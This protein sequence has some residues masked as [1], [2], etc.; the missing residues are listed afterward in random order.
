MAY[1]RWTDDPESL[2]I[3]EGS[4]GLHIWKCLSA[5]GADKAGLLLRHEDKASVG[6]AM[7]LFRSIN[8]Y[9]NANGITTK[10]RAGKLSMKKEN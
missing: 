8:D 5:E 3:W 2:Y 10:I 1:S 4:D 9:L 6:R 7:D